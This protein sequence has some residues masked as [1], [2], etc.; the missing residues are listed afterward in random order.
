MTHVSSTVHPRRGRTLA[1][2]VALAT[3][4]VM[5]CGAA[6]AK[7]T[8]RSFTIVNIDY[9][10][11]KIWVPST[12]VVN[13]GDTVSIK[14]INNVPGDPNQHG[15]AVPALNVQV[16]VT[17]GTPET[18]ELIAKKAGVYDIKCHLHPAHVGGQLVVLDD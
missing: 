9:E 3:S 1:A 5:T 13:E 18:V 10:G 15:F 4:I 7:A 8:T 14:L 2:A 11:S 12:L 16:V 17:R 6:H